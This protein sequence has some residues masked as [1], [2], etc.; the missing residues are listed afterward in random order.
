MAW[1]TNPG[2]GQR[3]QGALLWNVLKEKYKYIESILDRNSSNLRCIVNYKKL[4]MKVYDVK[5]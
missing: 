2:G 5:V 3:R 4:D 1:K